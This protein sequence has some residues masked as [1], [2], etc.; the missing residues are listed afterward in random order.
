S[1]LVSCIVS[2][3]DALPICKLTI[4]AYLVCTLGFSQNEQLFEEATA[5]YNQGEYTKAA[6]NYLKILENKEHSAELYF[7]LGNTYYK[8]NKRSEEHTSE[9]QSRENIVC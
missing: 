6:E 1:S 4:L 3:H 7:N 2:L 8:L 5:F 9:L